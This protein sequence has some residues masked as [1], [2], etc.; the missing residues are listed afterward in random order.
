[1]VHKILV[2][3]Y[4]FILKESFLFHLYLQ[5]TFY[6]LSTYLMFEIIKAYYSQFTEK[7]QKIKVTPQSS[8]M[9]K[10]VILH[11]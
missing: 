7:G 10:S 6:N 3:L 11:F 9:N 1:M 4:L 8:I 5:L 2:P